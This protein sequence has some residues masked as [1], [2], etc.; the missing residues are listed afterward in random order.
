MRSKDQSASEISFDD[1]MMMQCFGSLNPPIALYPHCIFEAGARTLRLVLDVVGAKGGIWGGYSPLIDGQGHPYDDS[2]EGNLADFSLWQLPDNQDLVLESGGNAKLSQF[3]MVID[4]QARP[5]LLLK[6]D[7]VVRNRPLN[8]NPY[9]Y[10]ACLE[11]VAK[12]MDE[13]KWAYIPLTDETWFALF[14]VADDRERWRNEVEAALRQSDEP[15]FRLTPERDRFHWIEAPSMENLRFSGTPLITIT[16]DETSIAK[17]LAVQEVAPDVELTAVERAIIDEL[18]PVDVITTW[19][20]NEWY[21]DVGDEPALLRVCE[22]AMK[23]DK[24]FRLAINQQVMNVSDEALAKIPTLSQL[25]G[26]AVGP[27]VTLSGLSDL[28]RH[29]NIRRL[30]IRGIDFTTEDIARLK[31]F[32]LFLNL[33][34]IEL[35]SVVMNPSDIALIKARE[36]VSILVHNGVVIKGNPDAWAEK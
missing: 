10:D 17:R 4:S 25:V 5:E 31:Y 24:K 11:H 1:A 32:A 35:D 22:L 7:D 8:T 26:I 20:A 9:Y 33:A 13:L 18:I 29:R 3:T 34:E 30:N 36:S 14:V 19:T 15:V 6:L 16:E 12:C 23:L 27:P 21:F 2:G 28:S